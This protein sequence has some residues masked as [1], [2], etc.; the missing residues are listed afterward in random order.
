MASGRCT[1]LGRVTTPAGEGGVRVSFKP[2]RG[3][4]LPSGEVVTPA[5]TVAWSS[6]DD[7]TLRVDLPW[8]SVVGQYAVSA[9]GVAFDIIVPDAGSARLADIM[10]EG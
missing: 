3:G 2:E 7:G 4:F 6:V 10:V 9:A 5:E 1:V 8:S